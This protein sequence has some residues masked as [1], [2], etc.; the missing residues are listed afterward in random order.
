LL[1][2][3][4]LKPLGISHDAFTL[5]EAAVADEILAEA[6]VEQALVGSLPDAGAWA[7]AGAR[8][9]FWAGGAGAVILA[10]RVDAVSA[11]GVVDLAEIP[12]LHDAWWE[13]WKAYWHRRGSAD[14]LP[15]DFACEVTLPLNGAVG[16]SER[17]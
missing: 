10:E 9:A 5:S 8:L 3:D 4:Q 1:Q 2:R 14:A 7:S 16:P 13:Y 17:M 11:A 6:E 12:K 15:H